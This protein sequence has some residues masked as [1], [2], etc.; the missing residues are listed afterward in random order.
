[1]RDDQGRRP[2]DDSSAPGLRRRRRWQVLTAIYWGALVAAMHVPIP[3]EQHGGP[4][5][6]PNTDKTVHYVLYGGLA[7]LL[8]RTSDEA[9][10]SGRSRSRFP[11][12]Y[13]AAFVACLVYGVVDELTQP[14]TGR[15]C[16]PADWY[17]D[18]GGATLG[19]GLAAAWR[20]LRRAR[21]A[22][23]DADRASLSAD[24]R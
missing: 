7:L 1:M 2:D 14:W 5:L 10:E 11:Y 22:E 21:A 13:G 9:T 23:S 20:S 18:V 8:C 4:K 19:V 16:E 17:A 3:D 6:P 24:V 15:R 12:S